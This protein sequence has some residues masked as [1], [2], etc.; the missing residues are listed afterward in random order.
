[1]TS[2]EVAALVQKEL[3]EFRYELPAPGTT[4][5]IPWSV[6]KAYGYVEQ[7]NSFLVKPYL[8]E[9]WLAD[10]YEQS[11]ASTKQLVRY[12]VVTSVR[13]HLEF[14]DASEGNFGLGRSFASSPTPFTIGVRGDLVG[15]FCAI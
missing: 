12:W 8:Q 11:S 13:D 2:E 7:L 5:G 4:I 14:F 10:T 3:Q 9:F 1:V 6:E 15:V